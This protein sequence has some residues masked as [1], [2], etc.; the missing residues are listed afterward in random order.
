MGIKGD[1]A[2]FSRPE[3]RSE[4][5]SYDCITPSAARG[6]MESVFWHP[7]MRFVIDRIHVVNPI[8]FM[9]IRRNEVGCKLSARNVLKVMKN[10]DGALQI[11]TTK[12]IQQRAAMVLRDVCYVIEAHFVMTSRSSPTDNP[13]KFYEMFNRRLRK[14]QCYNMPYLGCREFPADVFPLDDMDFR[15]VYNGQEKDLGFM[16]YDMDYTDP[17]DIHPIF[18]RAVIKDGV[19]DVTKPEVHI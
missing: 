4:Y 3:F 19:I 2:L 15:S 1:F 16:L 11:A 8:R 6:I 17:N 7:G 12:N 13:K 14:G 5:V 18:F 9:N 10:G